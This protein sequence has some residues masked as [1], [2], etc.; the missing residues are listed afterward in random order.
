VL[1]NYLHPS[2]VVIPA[3]SE[4]V[5][6]NEAQYQKWIAGG[7][8][9][10][11]AGVAPVAN[12]IPFFYGYQNWKPVSTTDRFDNGTFRVILGNDVAQR[13]IAANNVH[14]WPDGSAFAKIAYK[15]Q[16]DA[17]GNI[18]AGEFVQVE[19]MVKDANKYASTEGWGFGRWRGV[20]HTPYGKN[21]NFTV[22]CTSCHLPMKNNDYVYTMPI[23]NVPAPIDVFNRDAAL[24]ADLPYQPLQ[25]RVIT[26]QVDKQH[27]TMSTLYGNDSAVDHARTTPQS[28]YPAGA[29]LS[30]VTWDQQEDHHWFGG[31]IPGKVRTI[32]FVSVT[33]ASDG[34]PT[35][36][37]QSYS[38]SP[39]KKAPDQ[40]T[41]AVQ[42]R[43]D[44]IVGLKAAVM[45]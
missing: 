33:A 12:G 40:D 29:V 14:P 4:A 24:P 43:I 9:S 23:H 10:A 13:A 11:T 8:S 41:V 2:E 26:S 28:P 30:L 19:F 38:G 17:S 39:L 21:A 36:S 44:A 27:G 16:P 35:D 32:E 45:P 18:W 20:D 25:W 22:E 6:A 3:T 5:A 15:Q 31:R 1:K 42:P 34:K 37:Y 7:G